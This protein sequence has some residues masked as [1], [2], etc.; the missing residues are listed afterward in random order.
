MPIIESDA[1]KHTAPT[2]VQI[3]GSRAS[4]AVHTIADSATMYTVTGMVRLSFPRCGQN[5][6]SSPAD[7]THIATTAAT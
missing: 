5:H 2:A 7:A 1:A 3:V 6:T 4:N